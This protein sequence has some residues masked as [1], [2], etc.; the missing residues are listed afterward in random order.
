MMGIPIFG[1]S[2]RSKDSDKGEEDD[3]NVCEVHGHNY[4][5]YE[6][7]G[8]TSEFRPVSRR[9]KNGFVYE[10]IPGHLIG[11]QYLKQIQIAPCCDCP[12]EDTRTETIDRQIVFER[13]GEVKTID[14]AHYEAMVEEYEA[15]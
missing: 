3:Y 10:V 4:R 2:S 6:N 5:D 9:Y 14:M 11:V 8:V 13:D 15:E 7:K 12:E 1:G